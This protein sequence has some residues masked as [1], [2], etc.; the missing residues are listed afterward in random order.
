MQ[1]LVKYVIL[2]GPEPARPPRQPTAPTRTLPMPPLA[3]P[4]LPPNVRT[5]A[6]I[7]ATSPEALEETPL[8]SG[9]AERIGRDS[10]DFWCTLATLVSSFSAWIVNK[11]WWDVVLNILK[12]MEVYEHY[13]VVLNLLPVLNLL[14]WTL[15][16]GK[17]QIFNSKKLLS[18]NNPFFKEFEKIELSFRDWKKVIK[19]I[20]TK[21]ISLIAETYD[22]ES[23]LFAESLKAFKK[24]GEK[25]FN[26]SW[27]IVGDGPQLNELRNFC[28]SLKINN[29]IRL[30]GYVSEPQSL[31]DVYDAHNIMI[32]PSFTEAHPH[33]VD[34]CLSRIR[35][36][37]IFEDI[38][39]IVRDKKG[40]FVSKRDIESFSETLEYV[41]KNYYEIQKD[42]EKNKLPT[43]QD[44]LNEFSRILNE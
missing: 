1:N 15:T 30:L 27:D 2:A 10:Y 11:T 19:S 37:I 23:L 44:M 7:V 6:I 21:K 13:Y 35:P 24:I 17:F 32:L 33:V 31:I 36:V 18:K 28:V 39:Y 8:P 40:I 20:N 3:P 41:I 34:E 12:W 5:T 16:Q 43:K 14:F 38:S 22:K 26:F 25:G 9:T 4:L 42:I 29:N